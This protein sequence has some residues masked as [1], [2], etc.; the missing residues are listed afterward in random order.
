MRKLE[1]AER[2]H[3]G[4]LRFAAYFEPGRSHGGYDAQSREGWTIA[5]ETRRH[6]EPLRGFWTIQPIGT[7]DSDGYASLNRLRFWLMRA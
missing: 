5:P 6:L 3:R 2:A 7:A 1:H 4:R